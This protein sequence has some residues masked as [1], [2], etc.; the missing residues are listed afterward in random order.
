[1]TDKQDTKTITNEVCAY[2]D[3]NRNVEVKLNFGLGFSAG[4]V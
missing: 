4:F 3:C 1:M 2:I